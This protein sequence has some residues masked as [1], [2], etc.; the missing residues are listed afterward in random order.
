MISV[1]LISNI[2]IYSTLIFVLHVKL[3]SQFPPCLTSPFYIPPMVILAVS[4][5]VIRGEDA[6]LLIV[7]A[8]VAQVHPICLAWT[9]PARLGVG[10]KQRQHQPTST[11]SLH[12]QHSR[13]CTR[14]D[15]MRLVQLALS[16]PAGSREAAW[17]LQE[18]GSSWNFVSKKLNQAPRSSNV[19]VCLFLFLSPAGPVHVLCDHRPWLGQFLSAFNDQQSVQKSCQ[20]FG[21]IKDDQGMV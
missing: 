13:K 12:P 6:A 1:E 14:P 7:R 8:S 4:E 3:I 16:C 17:L 15:S 5:D 18:L 2:D 11:N 20:L 19:I 21:Q 9:W 10:L